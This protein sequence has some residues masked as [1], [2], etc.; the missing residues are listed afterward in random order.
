MEDPSTTPEQPTAASIL[1][2]TSEAPGQGQKRAPSWTSAEILDLIEVWG[3]VSNLQDLHTRR[4][5]ADTYSQMAT[6]LTQ[7][8]HTRTLDQVCM[9]I[10]ELR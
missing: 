4:R 6:S 7:K 2:A 8:G 3:E 10:K 9:K 5:N 1:A